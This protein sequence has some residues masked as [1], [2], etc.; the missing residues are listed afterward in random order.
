MPDDMTAQE[1]AEQYGVSRRTV[2]RMVA[3][4]TLQPVRRLPGLTGTHL[5]ARE[6]VRAL[7]APDRSAS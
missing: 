6:D 7:F 1:I 4:G 3:A 5:F 2:R